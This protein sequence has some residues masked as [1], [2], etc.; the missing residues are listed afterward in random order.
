MLPLLVMLTLVM[1]P[2]KVAFGTDSTTATCDTSQASKTPHQRKYH[3]GHYISLNR[4][5]K[6]SAFSQALQPGAIGIQVRYS[7][8]ELEPEPDIY[9][10]TR[11]A[12]ALKSMSANQAQLVVFIEDKTFKDEYPTPPYLQKDFTLANRNGGYT[13]IR[14]D[15]YVIERMN[16]LVAEIGRNFDCHP[17]FEGIAFQ[18]SALSLDGNILDANGYT[19]TKYKD[20]LINI[21]QSA[22]SNLP[23]SQIFW[24]MNFLPRN[25]RY[26]ANIANIVSKSGIAMGGPDILP[27][28][29]ALKENVYPFFSQFHGKMT[30][31]NSMQYDSFAHPKK[32][33]TTPASKYWTMEELFIFARDKLY[34]NYIFWNHKTWRRPEDSYDWTDAQPVISEHPVFNQK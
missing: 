16:K 7:W 17:N 5:E 28:N 30:L 11:I 23:Q 22:A 21:L 18:E 33:L 31:F 26:I 6:E 24:Y 19:A 2:M 20:A 3:P 1:S 13:T 12:T 9:D 4:F 8:R 29:Y 32:I 10:L 34:V 25:Q 15:P 27:D 14:W